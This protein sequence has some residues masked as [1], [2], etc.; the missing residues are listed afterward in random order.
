MK[1]VLIG[2]CSFSQHMGFPNEN[3][4]WN[5]LWTSWTDFF[6]KDY[7]SE[8][9][10]I[11]RAQSSFGQSRIV[12]SITHEL[13]ARKFDIDYVIIQWSAVGRSYSTNMNDFF[14]RMIN[15]Y[16]VPFSP[17]RHEYIANDDKLGWVTDLTNTIEHSFYIASLTQIY[18]MKCLLESKNI[19]YKM[20][21]G[22]GQI[23][24][25][26]ESKVSHLLEVIYDDRFLRYGSNHGGI[27]EIVMDNIG[28]KE[29][30][31]SENDIHPSTKGQEF[32]YNTTI[33]NIIKEI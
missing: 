4:E 22:W 29:G 15:Q 17:H 5:P 32:F 8:F 10:I 31:V 7:K 24:P 23:T 2:G 30:F 19:R 9:E 26:I 28:K 3:N 20:F 21:W 25:E 16:E 18:L 14:D 13:I 6:L 27:S 11:N 33:K 12:E 1:K